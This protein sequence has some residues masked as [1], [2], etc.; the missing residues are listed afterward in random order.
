MVFATLTRASKAS[1][2]LILSS[3]NLFHPS[4]YDLENVGAQ[5]LYPSR[6]LFNRFAYQLVECDND[7]NRAE[8]DV[9]MGVE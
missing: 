1:P 6:R 2:R 4:H 8:S 7:L 3:I 5:I 9:R